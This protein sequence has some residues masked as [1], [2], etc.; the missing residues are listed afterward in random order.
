[1]THPIKALL[2]VVAAAGIAAS[3][4][5][6]EFS[7]TPVRIFMTPKDR[8][9]AITLTNESDEVVVMQAELFLWKQKPD[10][11][12]DLTPTQDL[13]LSPPIVK[14]EPRAR[15]VVRLARLTPPPAGS[16]ETYRL[17][18]REVPE[19][20]PPTKEIK[21]QLALAFSLPVFITPTGAKRRMVCTVERI[22]ADAARA[23][24]ENQGSAYA[25]VRGLALLA[26]AG[27][28][29]AVRETGGYILPEIRRSFDIKRAEGKIPAGPVQLQVTLDDGS[30]QSFD[31]KMPD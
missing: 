1:M 17:I 24:C 30:V 28:K 14:L 20:K 7:V 18:V 3:A 12:D 19:A 23:N 11:Q 25:Q 2:L 21:L 31:G 9:V 29:L 22:A 8:A 6:A 15:Q 27:D 16:E 26:A 10:G 13:V 5:A 4:V